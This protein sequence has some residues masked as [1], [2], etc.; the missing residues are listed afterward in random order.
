MEVTGLCLFPENYWLVPAGN[1]F[2]ILT[3][4]MFSAPVLK[5]VL[6]KEFTLTK[7]LICCISTTSFLHGA[8]DV[9]VLGV[10]EV[11]HPGPD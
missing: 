2:F 10:L 5:Y 11:P 6:H 3:L 1:R 7:M 8:Q 9:H 4:K